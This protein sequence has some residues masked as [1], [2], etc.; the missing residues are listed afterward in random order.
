MR[1]AIKNTLLL[2]IPS[3]IACLL[4][5]EIFVRITWN[6]KDGVPGLV[7]THPS[8]IETL[9]P[10]YR[11]YFAGQPLRVNNLGF[12]DDSDYS[13]AKHGNTF[14]LIVLGDSVTFGHGCK[15]TETWPYILRRMLE[16]WDD[17]IEWQVWNLGV[18]GYDSV[19]ELRALEE[20][21]PVFKPD[22]VVVGFYEND[23]VAWNYHSKQSQPLWLFNIKRFLKQHFYLYTKLRYAFNIMTNLKCGDIT[24]S[25][26]EQELLIRP[27]KETPEFDF[28]AFRLKH[29]ETGR[30]VP[31]KTDRIYSY[32]K[33]GVES[34]STAIARFKEY[35]AEGVYDIAFFINISP[36]IDGGNDVFIDGPHNEMNDFFI[37]L[38]DGITPAVSSYGAFWAYRPSEV[39]GAYGH[40]L[41]EANMVKA[42][43]LFDFLT[44]DVL[45][46]NERFVR[47]KRELAGR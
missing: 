34:L 44:K 43:V 20:V 21:G 14:R 47:L 8:R 13:L 32:G 12:R 27:E 6:K 33:E 5:A 2:T 17:S 1:Q 31:P 36:D 25:Q 42:D 22:L 23:L 19:L 29:K 15:F 24:Q 11:G 4:A 3:L 40:S 41:A 46:K 30:P 10:N 28:S 38:L 39:K 35:K 7:L 37:K 45:P 26:R 9:A 16:K 18:P